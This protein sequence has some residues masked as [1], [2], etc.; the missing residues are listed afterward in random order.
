[1]DRFLKYPPYLCLFLCM[2]CFKL[3]LLGNKVIPENCNS[4]I[5]FPRVC[6]LGIGMVRFLKCPLILPVT[7]LG[8]FQTAVAR[9]HS[10]PR[11][12]AIAPL[13]SQGCVYWG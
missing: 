13:N 3:L 11:K 2:E 8:M 7:R 1:M 10:D 5:E 6:L 4:T 12:M 9:Q